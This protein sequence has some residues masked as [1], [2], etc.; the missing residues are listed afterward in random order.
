MLGVPASAG[1]TPLLSEVFYDAPG[2]DDGQVF[3]ELWGHPGTPLDGLVLEGV[4]GADGATGPSVTLAG[5]IPEDGLFVVADESGG[6]TFVAG[7]DQVASF[8]FQNGPDSVVLRDGATVLDALGYGSFDPGDVFAGE[9]TPAP[10]TPSGA[11]LARRFADV[12]TD[13]NGADFVV[14]DPPTPGA[15][16]RLHLVPEPRL[17]VVWAAAWVAAGWAL[18]R[19]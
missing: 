1:A 11:S 8:D 7:V 15:A 4:N 3:V 18:R 12:D 16:P 9:G 13:D 17:S 19:R 10:D 2:S 6:V 14:L 5:L